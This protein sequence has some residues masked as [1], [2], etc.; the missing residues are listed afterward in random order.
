MWKGV[1]EKEKK[2]GGRRRGRGKRKNQRG[3]KTRSLAGQ[4]FTSREDKP[5]C[6]DCFGEL[7]SKR[8]NA[9][10]KPITGQNIQ[11]E[12]TLWLFFQISLT[13]HELLWSI[14]LV[15][16]LAV[17]GCRLVDFPPSATLLQMISLLI[18]SPPGTL[19]IAVSCICEEE[20][21]LSLHHTSAY[22]RQLL[23]ASTD[24]EPASPS[25]MCL[26]VCLFISY[27]LSRTSIAGTHS[28]GD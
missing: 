18:P 12:E 11:L 17:T 2:R 21:R 28:P 10:S 5:Y 20:G 19:Q 25:P 6:A 1:E 24:L 7:F 8:C 3:Y 16:L 14:F 27:H 26:C 4:R 9:C 13:V 15:F 22:F 23:F